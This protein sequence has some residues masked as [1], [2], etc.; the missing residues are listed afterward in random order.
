[1]GSIDPPK[2]KIFT[3][4]EV[5]FLIQGN[6][7]TLSHAVVP[8]DDANERHFLSCG[9]IKDRNKLY[10]MYSVSYFYYASLHAWVARVLPCGESAAIASTAVLVR[11][12]PTYTDVGR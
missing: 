11:W 10:K 9:E 2:V 12:R 7:R 4:L 8:V 1:M 6:R 5:M 3:V